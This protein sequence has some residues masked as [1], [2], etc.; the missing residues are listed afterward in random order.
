MFIKEFFL[1]EF[2]VAVVLIIFISGRRDSKKY[3]MAKYC[4]II[5]SNKCQL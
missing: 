1:F 3:N 2:T 4:G 5:L